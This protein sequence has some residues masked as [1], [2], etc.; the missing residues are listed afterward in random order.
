MS[1]KIM[2]PTI[3]PYGDHALLIE[4][5]TDGFSETV[6]DTIHALAAKLRESRKYIE[7]VPGYDSLVCV[8]D[9]GKRSM[10]ATKNHVEDIL[11]RQTLRSAEIGKLVEIPVNYGGAFGPD[12]ETICASAKLSV[13]EV[14]A[15][16]S[17]SEYRVCMMGFI[18]GF[19]FLSPAPTALHHPRLSTPRAKVP[20][21]S[22][23]I[24]NWQTGIYG[25][26]SP[27]GWQ[28]IG[29]TPLS[30]FQAKR[31]PHFLLTAGD[32]VRFIPQ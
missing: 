19:T 3:R 29:Q 6:N 25:L 4:W 1:P 22:V 9:L 10:A 14:I 11:S 15:L 30:I 32:R 5:K 18:P 27:G 2:P 26:E 28:I 16:H 7:V 24:A 12:M 8:F 17:Q 13:D 21:G 31:E 20:A 23:G